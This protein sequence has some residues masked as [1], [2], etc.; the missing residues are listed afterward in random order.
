[1]TVTKTERLSITL[2]PEIARWI[3]DKARRGEYG[4]NS[5]VI[6]E[7][8]RE[9]IE[10]D[11]RLASLDGAIGRGIAD[12]KAGRVRSVAAVRAAR[13]KRLRA[14]REK[15][16]AQRGTRAPITDADVL[17]VVRKTHGR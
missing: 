4:S 12:A 6:R 5:A 16:L 14:V 17:R 15:I 10:R 2:P 1:M 7:A 3:R 13:L 11:Q 9:W 8:L